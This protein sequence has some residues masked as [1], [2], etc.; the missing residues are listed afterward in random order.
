MGENGG[1]DALVSST[2]V[3]QMVTLGNM[4]VNPVT[5]LLAE[6]AHAIV[7]R[8]CETPNPTPGAIPSCLKYRLPENAGELEWG[9]ILTAEPYAQ[10]TSQNSRKW[11][12]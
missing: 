7:G 6:Y 5:V 8:I 11:Y 12:T 10:P 2:V 4:L 9:L 1:A 3:T